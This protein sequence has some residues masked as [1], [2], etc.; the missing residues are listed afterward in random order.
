MNKLAV[1]VLIGATF[2]G[3]AAHHQHEYN[4]TE[5]AGKKI[6]YACQGEGK[7]TALLVSGMGLDAHT[8]YKNT[9]HNANPRGY[10]LCFYDRAGYGESQ[11][12]NPKVRTMTE[13][14]DELAGLIKH[15]KVE[16][17]VLVPHSFGGFVARA[18][19]SKYPDKVKGLVLIDT[20]HE[21]WYDAMKAQM[22]KSGWDT[23]KM[24]INWERE[25]NSFEDF[26]EASS[27]SALYTIKAD[28]PVTVLSRGI[29]HVTIRQTKMSYPDI[30]VY[31]QTWND[32][33]KKL[34]TL[35]QNTE[36]VTM[37]YASHLFDDS[38]PWIAIK[39][40]E[41]MVAKASL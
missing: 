8:T 9:Y 4:Y 23:M 36:A 38:D 35:N 37:K 21:S 33:Q 2:S 25:H 19:A 31:T 34:A 29:P 20:V 39:H 15:L 18:Y 27:H 6:A 41:A 14:R 24:I 13:L 30:D 22:S 32:A 40:I 12:D 26:E 28:L 1:A 11:Y 3:H 7:V 17:L 5:I 16:S 10:R